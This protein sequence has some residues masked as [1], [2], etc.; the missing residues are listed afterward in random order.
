MNQLSHIYTLAEAD[1][2][3]V[4]LVVIVIALVV[5]GC[6]GL[7]QARV[8]R[9]RN[10]QLRRILNALDSYRAIVGDRDL[11]LDEQ[12]EMVMKKS[13]QKSEMKTAKAAPLDEE[14]AFFVKMDTRVNKEKPFTDPDFDYYALIK[15]MGISQDE[16]CRLVPRYKDP[17][18]TKDYIN[19]LRAEYAAKLLIERSGSSMEDMVAMCGFKDAAAFNKAFKFS[20]GIMPTDYLNSIRQ[21][22]KKKV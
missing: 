22:F 18:R 17:E 1:S 12:E 21:M 11:S 14:H 2:I 8:I 4:I 15:F 10:E 7:R 16:F 6:I 13:E 3:I 20:F 5:V 19:S 9:Q